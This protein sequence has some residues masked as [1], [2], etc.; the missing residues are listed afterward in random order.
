MTLRQ[1]KYLI[2]EFIYMYLYIK[3]IG[4]IFKKNV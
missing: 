4:R 3:E 1:N 2:Y